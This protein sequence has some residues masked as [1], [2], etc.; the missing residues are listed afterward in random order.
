MGYKIKYSAPAKY[1][2]DDA[3]FYYQQIS[4]NVLKKFRTEIKKAEKR[5]KAN[6]FFQ[7]KYKSVH[8]LPLQGFPYMILFEI[9][10]TNSTVYIVGVFCTHQNPEKYP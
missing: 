3:Y 5:L 9:D 6:P 2:L 10:E 4:K 7:I 8:S 1:D